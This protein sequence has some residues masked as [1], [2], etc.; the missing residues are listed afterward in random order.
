MRFK[1]KLTGYIIGVVAMNVAAFI[2]TWGIL[3]RELG[4]KTLSTIFT[5]QALGLTFGIIMATTAIVA[6]FAQM[7]KLENTRKTSEVFSNGDFT[8]RFKEYVNPNCFNIMNCRETSCPSNPAS[9]DYKEGPCWSI[10]GSSAPVVHCPRIL[11][12]KSNG[13]LDSCEECEVFKTTAVDEIGALTRSLNSFIGRFQKMIKDIVNDSDG[14]SSA[15]MGLSAISEQMSSSAKQTSE[16]CKMV[17]NAAGEMSTNMNTI[18]AATNQTST[19][20]SVVATSSESMTATINEIA[21]ITEKARS[22]A[23]SAVSEA[24]RASREMIQL[25][26]G[27]KQIGKVTEAI[28]EISEQ[29]NLLAL[30][31]TIEAARAGEAGKGFAVVANEIKELATQTAS[32]TVEIKDRIINIQQATTSTVDGIK[33]ITETVDGLSEIVSTVA[34]AIEEQSEAVSEIAGGVS[35][36]AA[37]VHEVTTNVTTSSTVAELIAEEISLVNSSSD[38]ITNISE[39][40]NANGRE[41]SMLAD[42][43]KG[44]VSTFTA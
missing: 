15:V 40:V 39:Q 11:K 32:A 29:T 3:T 22:A 33:K 38:E 2:L 10:S 9:T 23:N 5:I 17:S 37:G 43:L 14:L 34:N 42:Q 44:L 36:A 30:N 25:D 41:L 1:R 35:Q 19:N 18:A 7:K 31:A 21:Q 20:V 13:G 6:V 24:N 16:K 8:R 27:A 26:E 28:A 4:G 12:G